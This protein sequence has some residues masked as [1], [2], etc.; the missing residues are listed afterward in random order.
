MENRPFKIVK[1][2]TVSVEDLMSLFNQYQNEIHNQLLI[3]LSVSHSNK[4]QCEVISNLGL[5]NQNLNKVMLKLLHCPIED[6]G[7][8]ILC[9][10]IS[11]LQN[12]KDLNLNFSLTLC[13]EQSAN[14]ISLMLKQLSNLQLLR[15]NLYG[16]D[17]GSQGYK[18]LIKSISS[19]NNLNSLTLGLR[20]TGLVEQNLENTGIYLNKLTK[21]KFLK[22]NFK[23]SQLENGLIHLFTGFSQFDNLEGFRLNLEMSSISDLDFQVL[24]QNIQRNQVI[25]YL[26]LNF[27]NNQVQRDIMYNLIIKI[28]DKKLFYF[29]F[30]TLYMQLQED[31]IKKIQNLIQTKMTNTKILI[32]D[33]NLGLRISFKDRRKWQQKKLKMKYLVCYEKQSKQL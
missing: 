5:N 18:E 23:D 13:T 33:F 11:Q 8:S 26:S 15:I 16:N 24:A 14:Q 22:L 2:D 19:L 29:K 12:L 6:S 30:K 1:F 4:Q 32:D 28:A 21:L 25:K 31:E 27:K 20:R 9:L 3:D 7:I 10:K 17:L